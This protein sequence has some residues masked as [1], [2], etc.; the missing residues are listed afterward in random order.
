MRRKTHAPWQLLPATPTDI[1][2]VRKKCRRMV[3]RRAA[4]S[5]GLSAVPIP[6]L[7]F[8]TDLGFL[9]RVIDDINT[10]FGLSPLQIARLQPQMRLVIYEMTLGVG[11]L[12]IGRVITREV[13]A[14]LLKRG[15]LKFL[16][17]YTAKIVPIAGQIAAAGIGFATFRTLA[18]QHI[19]ACALV[20]TEVMPFTTIVKP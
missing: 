16:A 7:D 14:Q 8:A 5:A 19:E 3:L 20:A 4:M 10:E 9:A 17:K 2:V 12:M 13:V 1:E 6:G 11:G 18:N 15:G